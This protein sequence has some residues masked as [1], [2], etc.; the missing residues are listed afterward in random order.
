MLN[1]NGE[2]VKLGSKVTVQLNPGDVV[3][4]RT[5]GGGGYNTPEEREPQLVLRDVRDGK[6]HPAR[7]KE[8]YKVAIDT[9]TWTIDAEETAK[10][11]SGY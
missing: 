2:A 10:L 1:P 3:S 6:V 5:C 8:I 11:R 9:D 4:F 7:A